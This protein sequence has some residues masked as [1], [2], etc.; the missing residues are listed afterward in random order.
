MG[1]LSEFCTSYECLQ[2]TPAASIRSRSVRCSSARDLTSRATSAHRCVA[3]VGQ[4]HDG[5]AAEVV[6]QAPEVAGSGAQGPL[7]DDVLLGAV[8]ALGSGAE[9]SALQ[10]GARRT[11]RDTEGTALQRSSRYGRG[12]DYENGMK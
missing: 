5:V 4:H 9:R 8:V 12:D 7:G 11:A 10:P 1:V 3:G 6:G 2:Q